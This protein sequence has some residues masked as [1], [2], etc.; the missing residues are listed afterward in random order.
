MV[1][2]EIGTSPTN[3][4][5]GHSS[6]EANHESHLPGIKTV[7]G[8]LN[9][10]EVITKHVVESDVVFHVATADHLA[11]AQAIV[12]G[13]GQRASQGKSQRDIVALKT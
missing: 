6:R 1:R 8:D 10:S 4:C 5:A 9:D 3:S 2:N 12:E 7:I 13:I 11:S